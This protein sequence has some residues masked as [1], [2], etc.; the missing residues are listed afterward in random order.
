MTSAVL[1]LAFNRPDLLTSVLERV[2]IANPASV[3]VVVDGPRMDNQEDQAACEANRQV[4]K[5]FN[6]QLTIK[7]RF[8]E[9][10]F[11]CKASVSEGITWFLKDVGEG[12]IL[13]DDC[14]P[15]P[16]FFP[17][18]DRFLRAYRESPD[19]GM[20]VG[21]HYKPER[22]QGP[23]K[24]F[25]SRYG[26]VWGWATWERA[27]AKYDADMADWGTL[28][29]TEWLLGK[30]NGHRD[31]EFFWRRAFDNCRFNGLD[32]WAWPWMYSLWRNDSL[33]LHSN[34]NLVLNV[35][36]VPGATH[37]RQPVESYRESRLQELDVTLL[38]E[39]APGVDKREDR[40]MDLHHFQTMKAWNPIRRRLWNP[41]KLV[42]KRVL[43]TAFTD[44]L[45][46]GREV[47]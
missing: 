20:L 26:L 7:T 27:W 43:P 42:A 33:S 36:F 13:E 22:I 14:L 5:R 10:N 29:Q 6:S 32:S 30:V 2:A 9:E 18:C 35:G 3:H 39:P 44:R 34:R 11:G 45:R 1:V 8:R 25:W 16:S 41:M 38:E 23:E 40:W 37:T 46:R 17:F 19:V 24:V 21:T 15:S 4:V 28:R 47:K 12:I 31:A